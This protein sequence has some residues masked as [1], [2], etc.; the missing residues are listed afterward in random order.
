MGIRVATID[1]YQGEESKIVIVSLVRSNGIGQIGFLREPE[2]VNV[3]LSRARECEI[4]IGN[5]ATL[6]AAK[7]T[8]EPLR[9]G[10]LR[11]K[12]FDH[13]AAKQQVFKGLP[14]VCQNHGTRHLLSA[15]KDFDRYCRDGGCDEYCGK[16]LECDHPC[17]SRCHPGKCK[18][19]LCVELCKKEL[20]CGHPCNSCCHPGDCPKCRVICPNVCPRGHS[21]MRQCG[22]DHLSKCHRRIT[23]MCP[24]NHVASGVCYAGKFGS[25]CNIC[26]NLQKE[27]EEYL[28]REVELNAA[29]TEK[30]KQLSNLM[31]DLEEK[32]Q[33]KAN[34]EELVALQAERVLVE[35]E[36]SHFLS[37]EVCDEQSHESKPIISHE[38][39][40]KIARN[41]VTLL[42]KRDCQSV[43][44]QDFPSIYNQEFGTKFNDDA[45]HD[46]SQ[47]NKRRKLKD[48]LEE[49]PVCDV[50]VP[51]LLS[52]SKK[53]K[54]GK[55]KSLEYVVQLRKG[56]DG[57]SLDVPPL[58]HQKVEPSA[59]D[60]TNMPTPCEVSTDFVCD[61]VCVILSLHSLRI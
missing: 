56:I 24:L 3:M 23:W 36:L 18:A 43:S 52:S 21:L 14:S 11:K 48:I 7:G 38:A 60:R 9:G 34:K 4:I 10:P 20:I 26:V 39:G 8:V 46:S 40:S 2:R 13:L 16:T 54:R 15:P 17:P 25:D 22:D 31:R 61:K 57:F 49:L 5:R 1:N 19:Y 59:E 6:E 33:A 30:R 28:K 55:N 50:V 53:K 37:E 58:K 41:V 51:A 47:N 27:E 42:K 44:L 32:K 45:N 35:E 29:L 12:I